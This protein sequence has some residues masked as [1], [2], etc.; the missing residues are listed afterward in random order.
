VDPNTSLDTAVVI[1][2]GPDTETQTS[3]TNTM[4]ID[5]GEEESL[6][7]VGKFMY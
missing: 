2:E 3:T 4:D 1:P 5:A 7:H 6:P